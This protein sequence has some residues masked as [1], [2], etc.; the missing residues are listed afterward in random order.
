[1]AGAADV[2]SYKN[3]KLNQYHNDIF[4]NKIFSKVMKQELN[5]RIDTHG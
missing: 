2:I 1:M 5:L 4:I 3:Y